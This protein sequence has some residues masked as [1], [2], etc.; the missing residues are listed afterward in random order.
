MCLFICT[1]K[2]VHQIEWPSLPQL[3][4]IQGLSHTKKSEK[5]PFKHPELLL[6]LL[7]VPWGQSCPH[8]GWNEEQCSAEG[9]RQL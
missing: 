2:P 5:C 4:R 6:T 7:I 8:A 3:L 9:T 1:I